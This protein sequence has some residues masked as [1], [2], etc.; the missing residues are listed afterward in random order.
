ME[1]DELK[2]CR[3]LLYVKSFTL[4]LIKYKNRIFYINKGKVHSPFHKIQDFHLIF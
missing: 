3:L 1:Q 4:T 2:I